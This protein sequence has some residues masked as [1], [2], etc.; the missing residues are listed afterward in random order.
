MAVAA[1]ANR[2]GRAKKILGSSVLTRLKAKLTTHQKHSGIWTEFRTDHGIKSKPIPGPH[3]VHGFLTTAPNA[4]VESIHPKAMP[5]I[6][7]TEEEYMPG[8]TLWDEARAL[9][10]SLA[11][12]AMKIVARGA[13][14]IRSARHDRATAAL[15]LLDQRAEATIGLFVGRYPYSCY[16]Q[17]RY[18]TASGDRLFASIEAT[19]SAH[20]RG[21]ARWRRSR[22]LEQ[23][24]NGTDGE[25][26]KRDSKRGQEAWNESVREYP[27]CNVRH[28]G[29]DQL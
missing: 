27:H 24:C 9:Q 5:V 23:G 25:H 15:I 2:L 16:L 1:H 13:D 29:A 18:T 28:L 20:R 17:V 19:L 3:L 21:D 7:T 10:R 26:V 14:K 22:I 11:D 6:L 8:C 12:D 4:I